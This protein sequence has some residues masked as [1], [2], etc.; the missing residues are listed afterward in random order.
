[1]EQK[2]LSQENVDLNIAPLAFVML[3]AKTSD[4]TEDMKLITTNIA[5]TDLVTGLA[6]IWDKLL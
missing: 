1:M 3:N 6:K 4:V 2:S 5:G